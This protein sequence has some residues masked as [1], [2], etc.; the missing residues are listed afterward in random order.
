MS[1]AFWLC[2]F[3]GLVIA[4]VV[5]SA[6]ARAMPGDVVARG[7]AFAAAVTCAGLAAGAIWLWGGAMATNGRAD[8]LREGALVRLSVREIAVPID[9]TITVGHADASTVQLPGTGPA[10]IVRVEVAGTNVQVATSA[11][12]AWVMPA[13][14]AGTLATVATARCKS[15]EGDRRAYA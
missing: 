6:R 8:R 13:E 14:L 4:A 10:E 15:G 5:A 11:P 2:G 1:I 7:A 9:K 3:V 12:D